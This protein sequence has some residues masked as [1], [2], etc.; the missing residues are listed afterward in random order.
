VNNIRIDTTVVETMSEDE[1]IKARESLHNEKF[2]EFFYTWI[3]AK[4]KESKIRVYI[5]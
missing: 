4:R 2:R 1:R 5:Q 3:E